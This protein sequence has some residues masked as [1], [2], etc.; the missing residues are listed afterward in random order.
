M[1]G[2]Y[3]NQAAMQQYGMNADAANRRTQNEQ[4]RLSN[5]NDQRDKSVNEQLIM[6]RENRERNREWVDQ[7]NA[8]RQQAIDEAARFRAQGLNE[9]TAWMQGQQVQAPQF[10][11]YNQAGVAQTPQLLQAAGMQGQQNAANA[12]AQN[13]GWNNLMG[14]IGSMAGAGMMMSDRRLKKN[15]K[16]IGTKQGHAWY[17]FDYIWGVP[18]EGVM[19]DEIPAQFR[20]RMG[21]HDMVNYGELFA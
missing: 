17:S 16:R 5:M 9:V 20:V 13:A 11:Q 12:S 21:D 6:G 2:D 19:A 14:G 3:A 18:S 7:Q 1:M 10:Q 4:Y 15:I 8:Q